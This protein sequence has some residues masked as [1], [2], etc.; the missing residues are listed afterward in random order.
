M[1]GKA[2]PLRLHDEVKSQRLVTLLVRLIWELFH[3]VGLP[4]SQAHK[5]SEDLVATGTHLGRLERLWRGVK[6]RN[7]KRANPAAKA[8][9]NPEP[10][11]V[12]KALKPFLGA[13]DDEG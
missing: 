6:E 2:K 9:L 12:R 10:I 5:L 8:H 11:A 7:E 13:A 4:R 1:D 3:F